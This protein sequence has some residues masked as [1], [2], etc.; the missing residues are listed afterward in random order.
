MSRPL[1]IDADTVESGLLVLD[2]GPVT[3]TVDGP[4]LQAT[5]ALLR[6]CRA[7]FRELNPDSLDF[8]R[9]RSNGRKVY[10][11]DSDAYFRVFQSS[12]YLSAPAAGVRDFVVVG[13]RVLLLARPNCQP[14]TSE[15][16]ITGMTFR[17]I[18]EQE[19]RRWA[20]RP[21]GA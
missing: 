10:E 4:E 18:G 7:N 2:R 1:R 5:E 17:E 16:V 20:Q 6:W 13:D 8:T 3:H 21:F 12:D 19:A 15:T 14:V 9:S 11:R